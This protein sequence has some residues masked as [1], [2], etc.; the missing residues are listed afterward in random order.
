MPGKSMMLQLAESSN[1][2]PPVYLPLIILPVS[3]SAL[4]HFRTHLVSYMLLLA[5]GVH[6]THSLL[7]NYPTTRAASER[8]LLLSYLM[9]HAV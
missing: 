7:S 3:Y 9:P 1:L 2:C 5:L 4:D 6:L 8:S